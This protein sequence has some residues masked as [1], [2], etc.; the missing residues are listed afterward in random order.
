ME[1]EYGPFKRQ[2]RLAED[3]DPERA[4]ATYERGIV[5]VTLPVSDAVPATR[6]RVAIEVQRR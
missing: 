2:V 5:T 1:I 3:V 4:Q 6:G